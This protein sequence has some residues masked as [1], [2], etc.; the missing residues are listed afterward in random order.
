MH[1]A[2]VFGEVRAQNTLVLPLVVDFAALDGGEDL[3]V[4]DRLEPA[5][6]APCVA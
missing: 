3:G 6:L 4:S 1:E 5:K 2:Q